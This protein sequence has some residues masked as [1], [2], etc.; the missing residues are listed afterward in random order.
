[1]SYRN[2][3]L[4]SCFYLLSITSCF[5]ESILQNSLPKKKLKILIDS[6]SLSFSHIQFQ[7]KLADVLVEA[8]HEVHILMLNIDPKMANYTGSSKAYKVMRVERPPQ[9]HDV[10]SSVQDIDSPFRG[11][12]RNFQ[13]WSQFIE[14]MSGFCEDLVFDKELMASLKAEKYDVGISEFYG[15]CPFAIFH[16]VGIK[17]KIASYAIQLTSM[18]GYQFGIPTLSSYVP[19]IIA[20]TIDG[21]NMNF[22][23]RALNLFT[24]TYETFYLRNKSPSTIQ[25]I[26]NKAFGPDFPSVKEI[27]KNISLL[28]TNA[29]EFFEFPHPVS[30]KVIYIGGIVQSKAKPIQSEVK[31]V[32]DKS[33]KGVVLFS[34]G[35]ITDTTKMSVAMKQAFLK[36][37]AHFP[38]YDFIWKFKLGINDSSLL[39]PNV[40]LFNWLDQ[41]AVMEHLNLKAFITHCAVPLF[42][43]QLFNAALVKHK[44]IGEYVDIRQAEEP[45]VIID[46][47][48]QVLNNPIYRQNARILQK[49]LQMSPFKPAEKLVKW[50]EF[51]SEFSELNE[52][53]LPMDELNFF[54][55][56]CLDVIFAGIAVLIIVL[57]TLTVALR[58][59]LPVLY[60]YS[61][62]FI[63]DQ[64]INFRKFSAK[65]NR[66]V[67][68]GLEQ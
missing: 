56:Y 14:L 49:K 54:A 63:R 37:F 20:P 18:A 1:M 22:M 28:F 42:G 46:A 24:D 51:A 25:P 12:Q 10:M 48:D 62:I 52:L 40:H 31:A 35:S 6:P 65:Y 57:W 23:Q 2:I 5:A 41:K 33:N 50:V 8:G 17:T 26:V 38:Q 3:F 7:G 29:N 19:N 9:N 47:L 55:Y 32:L 30:N 34:F 45:Q 4:F 58:R 61:G 27:N 66:Y 53:N 15:H 13:M 59:L 39:A 16:H 67:R 11:V 21:A 60:H 36:A 43:D 68:G 64:S 44:A